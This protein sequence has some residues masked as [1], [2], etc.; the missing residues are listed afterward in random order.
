[1]PWERGKVMQVRLLGPVDVMVD[2]TARD[3]PG[4]RRKAV[5]A[6][7][8]LNPGEVLSTDRL[9]DIV[10][11]PDTAA[12]VNTL[13]SHVSYLRR[14]LGG[15]T[16]IVA[17]SP[18]YQLRLAGDATDLAVAEHLIERADQDADHAGGEAALRAA[19]ALWRGRPLADVADLGWFSEQAQRLEQLRLMA[20]EGLA[21]IR[22]ERGEH[23]VLVPE[24][25]SLT[26]QHPFQER[27]YAHLM[28]ALYRADRQHD[29]L[30]VYQRLAKL[31]DEELGIR[32]S[33]YLRD[34]HTAILRQDPQ[35]EAPAHPV[36]VSSPPPTGPVP[37]QLPASVRA[38]AGRVGELTRLN[39]LLAADPAVAQP[40]VIVSA[41]SGTAGVGKTAL[42]VYWAHRMAARFPD[43]QLYANLRGFDPGRAPLD[44]GEVLRGFLDALGVPARRVP[45]GLDAQ[46]GLYRSL[47]AD[48][49]VL[50]LL[51]N[52][53]DADQVRPL[54]PGSPGCLAVVT[55]RN[56]LTPLV[57]IDGAR[58]LT[59]GLLTAAESGELLS[60]R[61]GAGR[62]AAEQGVVEEIIGRC[63]GLP[64]A[65][66]I[67]AAR[68]E[69]D[70]IMPLSVLAGQL[71]D[72]AGPL[73]TLTAGDERTDLRA[74]FSWSTG[75]LSPQAAGLYWFLGLHPGPDL[76]AAAAASLAGEPAEQIRPQLDELVRAHLLTE[77]VP[78]RFTCHDLLRAYAAEQS[79]TQ[80]TG[81]DRHAAIHRMLDH[82]LHSAQEAARLLSGPWDHL[83]L[84]RAHPG[85]IPE[86]FA[87]EPRA[88]AWLHA[89]YQVLLGCIEYAA[90]AG[91]EQ[92]AWQLART[93]ASYFERSGH[94]RDWT[95][96]QQAA[97]IAAQRTGDIPGQAHCHHQLGY[98]LAHLGD[99]GPAHAE[100]DRA[101]DLF[102][103]LGDDIRRAL[104]HL[105]LGYTFDCQG[106]DQ[107]ALSHGRQ[108]LE[109]YRSAGHRAG[110]A[111][112]LNN[113]G[114]SY[115]QRGHYGEALQNCRQALHMHEQADDREGQAGT[116]DSLGYIHHCRADHTEAIACYTKASDLYRQSRD[117]YNEARTLTRLGDAHHAAG[118]HQSAQRAWRQAL[119]LHQALDHP[120]IAQLRRRLHQHVGKSNGRAL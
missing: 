31:L 74:V 14:L 85:V 21:R 37:A 33:T 79:R 81:D 89:E 47:L 10:W 32:P 113:I 114:W 117:G 99:Y 35:L 105:A 30:A 40:A 16:T 51:D 68:A 88:S 41:V 27:L 86:Q 65:L 75:T 3:V 67:V 55:S 25:E 9:L 23:A 84:T 107:Q 80:R 112:A 28:L 60:C 115:A 58:P 57:A 111:I 101:L 7:L 53:R 13:Q 42:A 87:D 94:W 118:D 12:R 22:L 43:G 70:P 104:V 69:T 102:G 2:G 109:L 72:S 108:A 83:P 62:V 49:R 19:L 44:P 50:L 18:G 93:M 34:L 116:W 39:D 52:A 17:R 59:L 95:R 100:L 64:L 90:D 26:R 24:L 61:L 103:D 48:K 106:A 45:P 96:T 11:G 4:L 56:Q 98:A 77:H 110:E 66:A 6:A 73:D 97:G 119:R 8:A 29:A 63:A 38:F 46:L 20:V 120:D 5:L 15:R 92:H 71:R 82:Y 36:I 1:M 91:F 76:T 54:L 78:G